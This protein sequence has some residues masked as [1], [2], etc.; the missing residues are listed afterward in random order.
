MTTLMPTSPRTKKIMLDV[1][2]AAQALGEDPVEHLSKVNKILEKKAEDVTTEE[3]LFL[4]QT[5]DKAKEVDENCICNAG[6][7]AHRHFCP[8][9][10]YYEETNE[11]NNKPVKI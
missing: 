11:S 5:I 1:I 4:L 7:A 3:C 9:S 10:P 6:Y 2:K 8:V